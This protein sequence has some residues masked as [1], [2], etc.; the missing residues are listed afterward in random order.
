[1]RVVRNRRRATIEHIV[2]HCIK[3]GTECWTDEWNGYHWMNAPDSGYRRFAVNH[4][5]G[6]VVDD[7]GVLATV[8]NGLFFFS[9]RARVGR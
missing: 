9:V 4:R 8:S 2:R 1:V 5:L 7:E 6:E 3:P